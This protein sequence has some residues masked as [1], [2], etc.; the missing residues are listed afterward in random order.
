MVDSDATDDDDDKGGEDWFKER[1]TAHAILKV[2]RDKPIIVDLDTGADVNLVD[3]SFVRKH[4][5]RWIGDGAPAIRALHEYTKPLGMFEVPLSLTDHNGILRK[6]SIPCLAVDRDAT[7]PPVLLGQP[8]LSQLQILLYPTTNDWWFVKETDRVRLVTAKKLKKMCQHGAAQVFSIAVHPDVPTPLFPD[9]QEDEQEEGPDMSAIPPELQDMA[10]VMDIR[11]SD[12]LPAVK[13]TDHPIDL[14]PGTQPPVGPIYP[15]SPKELQVLHDY[16]VENL[17]K[18]RIRPS[19]SPAASPVL[20]V[21]KK[22]GSFRLC[23]D[24]RGLNKITVKNR[25]PLPLISEILDRAKGAKFFTKIDV[26]DAYYR[27]RIREGD[28]WKTAFRTRYGLFEYMVMPFGLTNAPATF[29]NYIHQALGGLLDDCCIAYLDDILILSSDRETHTKHIRAVLQR[30]RAAQLYCNLK[31]CSFYQDRVDFLGFVVTPDGLEMD[32]SRIKTIRDWPEPQTFRDIQ[33][34]L[35]FCNFYRKFIRG[36]ADIARPLTN[37]LLGLEKGKKPGQVRF[38]PEERQA[39]E[40]LQDAFQ[41]APVLR[42]FDPDKPVI[43]ETDASKFAMGAVLSQVAEDGRKHPVAFWS[44]KF[45]GPALNY[46]TPDQEMMAIVEAFKHWRHYLE[47]NPQDITVYSDHQNLQGFMRQTSLNGRQAR[48]CMYL[49][50]FDFTIKH[51]AGKRNP[52]DGP[53]RRPDYHDSSLSEE[54]QW[55]PTLQNKLENRVAPTVLTM[56]LGKRETRRP[57]ITRKR[58]REAAEAEDKHAPDPSKSLMEIVLELQ[59]RDPVT[60]KIKEDLQNRRRKHVDRK[61]WSI[62]HTGEL[63]HNQRLFVPAEEAVK[64]EIMRLHHD[65]VRAGHFGPERTL[66]LIQRKFHWNMIRKSVKDYCKECRVCQTCKSKR[67]RPY[68]SLESLPL[69][70]RPW[71][72]ITMD[73]IVGLPA[74]ILANGEEKNAILVVV[75]RY[76]KMNRFFAVNSEI[77]SQ[78]MAEL[79]HREIELKYGVP[80]GCI[81]D[82]GSVFTAQFWADLCYLNRVHRKLSTAFHPQTDG[83]TERSNQTLGQYLRCFAAENPM[84]WAQVLPE[85]EFVCNNAVN[86]TT[87]ISPFRALMGYDPTISRRIEDDSRKKGTPH[88]NATERVEMLAQIRKGLERHW[89]EAVEN[90]KRFYDKKHQPQSFERGQLVLLST[91]NLQLKTP[92]KMKPRFIGP[93]RVL[94][95]VGSL[96]YRL[97]LPSQYSRLHDVFPVS[98]LEPWYG[99]AGIQGKE[100][101]MPELEDDEEWEVEE[102]RDERM[103]DGERFFMVKWQG[104]P[105]EFNQ[106]VM[107]E[108]MEHAQGAITR[109]RRD[110][111]RQAKRKRR[112]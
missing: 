36:F 55:L 89:A 25:Y 102:V 104:W 40:K 18:H 84:L 110:R 14:Q 23:V 90:H 81:S 38:T 88:P 107:E 5:L 22:D 10:D 86:A 78:E 105:S 80:D 44:A 87:K 93:F 35:G 60:Q 37:L 39:F 75:D 58:A 34:F 29:Q 77:K 32:P 31:K 67:H 43:L 101:P 94:E 17:A 71:Q 95:T 33:V 72:E 24:Y 6:G 53:S 69:P 100:M 16:I 30:L 61:T 51:Q 66:E 2:H 19:Q 63:L 8:G 12:I 9:E 4:G 15:L 49:A 26:K 112:R 50:G 28:E 85:A 79:I 62:G 65:D 56:R 98:L 42:H 83:Q 82:R 97:A 111:E 45:K 41:R 106:W 13:N 3:I 57:T 59:D 52:A 92:S 1:M 91:Q 99:N 76:T 70:S 64:Q 108:D 7:D 74:L 103:F 46:G 20:F 73:F 48:W 54:N 11:N 21:P 47:G 96:A 68:G 27:I 109:F